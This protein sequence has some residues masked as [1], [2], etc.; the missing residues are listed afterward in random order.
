MPWPRHS[1]PKDWSAQVDEPVRTQAAGSGTGPGAGPGAVRYPGAGRAASRRAW[2]LLSLGLSGL[3]TL[4]WLWFCLLLVDVRLRLL[5]HWFNRRLL[6]PGDVPS[7]DFTRDTIPVRP[8]HPDDRIDL[9]VRL[10][11]I[12]ARYIPGGDRS[13]LRRAL[14]LRHSLIARGIPARLVYGANRCDGLIRT[15]AW[16]EASG[17]KLDPG[18][19][20]P[21]SR[22]KPQS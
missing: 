12:A 16:V 9:L 17:R 11:G 14:V 18:G 6:Y 20:I 3:A 15:H 7:R 10:V 13:C 8:D 19:F 21:F 2:Q 5:P 1:H 4:G 22:S